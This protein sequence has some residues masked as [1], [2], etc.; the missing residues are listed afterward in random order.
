M[1]EVKEANMSI[2]NSSSRRRNYIQL[3]PHGQM[4]YSDAVKNRQTTNN[5]PIEQRNVPLQTHNT[6]FPDK[7]VAQIKF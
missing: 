6:K 5:K 1:I 3:T 4:R 7:V 2:G